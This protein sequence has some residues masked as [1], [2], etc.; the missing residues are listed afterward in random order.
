MPPD[1]HAPPAAQ[2]SNLPACPARRPLLGK[3]EWQASRSRVFRQVTQPLLTLHEQSEWLDRS[4]NRAKTTDSLA[5]PA[6][7]VYTSSFNPS[8]P[9]AS[10]RCLPI[11]QPPQQIRHATE[12]TKDTPHVVVVGATKEFIGQIPMVVDGNRWSHEV[13]P[14]KGRDTSGGRAC[15]ASVSPPKACL[16]E[17]EF[18]LVLLVL[19]PL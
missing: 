6:F 16:E 13:V 7:R 10:V 1:C 19:A 8:C 11:T 2:F 9:C 15:I 3:H 4:L 17:V 14:P 18:V 5:P 12:H